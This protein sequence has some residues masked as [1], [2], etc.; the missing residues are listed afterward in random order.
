L[1][2]EIE[3][4]ANFNII[5]YAQVWEDA[6]LLLSALGDVRG[7]TVFSIASAGDNA[8]ALLANDPEKV[9]AA[10]LS[11]A[12]IACCEL[13]KAMYKYLTY[14]EH[15]IFGGL[16]EPGIHY[17]TKK[18]VAKILK[19]PKEKYAE[20][21]LIIFFRLPLSNEVRSFWK[22]NINLIADGFMT[23]GKFERYF[24]L[25]RKIVL[26]LVHTKKEIAEL[27]APK[28]D[29]EREEFYS[30]TWDNRRW[31]FMFKLFFSRFVMGSLGRDKEF[32]KFV[33]GKVADNILLR[34]KHALC[35]MDTSQN[36]Y[37]HFIVNGSYQ[38][39]FPYS[40]RKEN[41]QKIK[42]NIDKIEFIKTSAEEFAAGFN[43]KIN[44]FNLSDIF[45]YMTE[46][47]AEKT[48]SVLL[49]KAA[50]GARFAYWNMLAPRKIS[51]NLKEKYSVYTSEEKNR[52]YLL[53]DKAFFYSKF[54]LDKIR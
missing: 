10:D 46:E 7:E 28:T 12:Q 40:L 15:L 54:Y 25:F 42:K 34:T 13:R 31:R 27:L 20:Q 47:G 44:A 9:Y 49:E 41:Y 53:S 1:S 52:E 30:K 4:R 26:P 51:D 11:F 23:K 38:D 6:D 22:A 33:E 36:P 16:S 32:F 29:A 50:P 43:G 3:S 14:N 24:A 48:Y 21:R 45:E 35:E 17:E 39:V 8:F 37:L 2:S 18:G 19:I 5:R